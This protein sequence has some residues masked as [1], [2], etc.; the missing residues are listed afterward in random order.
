[1]HKHKEDHVMSSSVLQDLQ[2]HGVLQRHAHT[3]PIQHGE[4]Y[5]LYLADLDG[6][7][8]ASHVDCY[9]D[10]RDSSVQE[11]MLLTSQYNARPRVDRCGIWW[12]IETTM[13]L[14]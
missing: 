14:A 13:Q 10:R 2:P 8:I 1:M 5:A 4:T 7:G 3:G 6:N 9:D 12:R 11:P